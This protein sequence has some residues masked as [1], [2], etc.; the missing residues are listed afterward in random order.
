MLALLGRHAQWG[1]IGGV[2][3]ALL[4]PALGALLRPWLAALVALVFAL[5]VM[6]MD[7]RALGR[8]LRT[9]QEWMF[10]GL[11][12]ALLMPGAALVYWGVAQ[13]LGLRQE[14]AVIALMIAVAPPISS[15]ANFALL[16]GYDAERAL[17][18]TLLG[19][20]LT[21]L[22]GPAMFA[23]LAPG[24]VA[25]SP[26]D[27][28][29]RLAGMVGAGVGLG[30]IGQAI[31]GHGRITAAKVQMDGLAVIGMVL[32]LPAL[33]DGLVLMVLA[34]PWLAVEV[35]VLVIV[36]NSLAMIAVLLAARCLVGHAQAGTIGLIWGNR[37]A[38]LYLAAMPP[39]PVLGLFVALYQFPMY[40]APL[41]LR[42][43]GLVKSD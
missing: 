8:A 32:I 29:L 1:L 2:V 38:A 18:I 6:R 26:M 42:T 24:A 20:A 41:I 4:F 40:A 43:L 10:L 31:L 12:L 35:L 13:G 28:A 33:M 16:L 21:P 7:F 15:A 39:D 19:K 36:L 17:V 30:V 34:D 27:M 9:R 37:N 5:A 14:F 25:L 11:M 22:I 3:L 23:M